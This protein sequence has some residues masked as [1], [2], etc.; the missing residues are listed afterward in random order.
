MTLGS[1][2]P[3]KPTLFAILMVASALTA[4][5]P[6][7]WTACTHGVAQPLSPV[8]WAISAGCRS[9]GHSARRLMQPDPSPAELARLRQENERLAR[10]VGQQQVTIAE[11]ERLLADLSGLRDQLADLRAEIIIARVLSGDA[12]PP[13]ETLLIGKGSRHGVEVGDWVAA[14]VPPE[15]LAAAE[16]GR[17]WVLRQWLIGRISDVQPF[18]SRVQLATDPQFGTERATT[19]KALPDGSWQSAGRHCGLVG[20]GD[21]R[22]MIRQAVEDYLASGFTIVLIPLAHPRPTALAVGRI[23]GAAVLDTGLHYD[24]TVEPWSDPRRLSYVFVL[25]LSN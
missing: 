12:A 6:S 2:R 16:T 14:G 9:I 8:T 18:T 1:W 19:A 24:L 17:D 4:L 21:G 15:A 7:E 20:V 22:M 5:L 11:L 13:R 23:T 25:S 10:Q 3:S